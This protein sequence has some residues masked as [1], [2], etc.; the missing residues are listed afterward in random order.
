MS[1]VKDFLKSYN[2]DSEETIYSS[3]DVCYRLTD[4]LEEYLKEQTETFEQK[5]KLLIKHLCDN[6]NPHTNIIVTCDSAEI[7]EGVM[8]FE[9]KKFIKD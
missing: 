3:K 6:H 5:S 4:I 7:L 9:T 1:D 8:S 2:I